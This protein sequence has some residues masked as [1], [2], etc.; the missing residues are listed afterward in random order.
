M[1]INMKP[2]FLPI[3]FTLG[4]FLFANAQTSKPDVITKKDNTRIEAIIKEI[5][6]SIIKYKK[7][8]NPDG[9]LFSIRR[10]EVAAILYANGEL[11][12]FIQPSKNSEAS[13]PLLSSEGRVLSE[14]ERA[15]LRSYEN[16][17]DE[18]LIRDVKIFRGAASKRVVGGVFCL[19]TG[20]IAIGAGIIM[21]QDE[22]QQAPLGFIAGTTLTGLGIACISTSG[23]KRWRY[24]LLD[25]EARNRGLTIAFKPDVRISNGIY[26]ATLI[27]SF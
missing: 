12:K 4:S 24:K 18:I 11:E 7:F 20:T 21:I 26:G 8:S 5:D 2:F 27:A 6:D 3:L 19:I 25:L 13:K 1:R 23:S 14:K 16:L 17:P 9:P 22:V 15:F 10:E